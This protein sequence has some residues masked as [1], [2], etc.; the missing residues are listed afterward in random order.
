MY[1]G[2][3]IVALWKGREEIFIFSQ[4]ISH[5]EFAAKM[6][7]LSDSIVSAGFIKI[8]CTKDYE[9]KPTCF[10]ESLTLKIESR[11]KED[12]VLAEFALGVI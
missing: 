1:K 8:G 9:A 4:G 6:R 11:P 3:Y 7:L 12:T 2:K 10:G 5:N